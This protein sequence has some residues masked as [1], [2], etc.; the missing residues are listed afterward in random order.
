[1][2]RRLGFVL[3]AAAMGVVGL[4]TIS[5]VAATPASDGNPDLPSSC[6]LDVT[7]V[8]D[9]SAS[10]SSTE[11]EL[12]RQ[13]AATFASA[14]V[15][16]PS[17]LKTV[18]F[19]SRAT[20]IA[21]N[22]STTSNLNSIVFRDPA[23]Y[24]AP[25]SGA[26]SGGTNWDDGLEVVRR[27]NGGPGDLVVFLTD[28]DP[29]YRNEDEPN[30]HANDGSHALD[31]DG[32]TIGVAANLTAAEFEADA[33]KT[34]GAHMFGIG[35]GL[36]S[37]A[38]ET[39]LSAV[40]GDEELTLDGS[41][42]PNIPF[43]QADY[44]IAPNFGAL[45]QIIDAFVR[46]LCAPSLNVT[47][48]LQKADGTSVVAGASD[49]WSF[50]AAVSPT[51]IAWQSP[52]GASGSSATQS[53]DAS[54]GVSFKWSMDVNSATVDLTETVKPGWVYNGALCTVNALD[55][56]DP[57]VILDTVGT[58]APGAAE[59]L[60]ELQDLTVGLEEAVNCDVYNRELR[61][62]TIQV[63]KR[64]VP[65]GLSDPF[66]FTL[67]SGQAS[68]DV[69]SDLT[70]GQTGTFDPVPAGTYSI[71]EAAVDGYELTSATCDDLG[72]QAVEQ[73]SPTQLVTTE[74]Q[75]WRCTFTNTADPGSITVVKE[76][77]GA[78]GTFGFT[79][80]V[81][82]LGNFSLTTSLGS[83][84]STSSSVPVGTYSIEENDPAP[85]DLT[86]ATCTGQQD[87][88]AVFVG[89]GKDVVCTFTNVAPQ[90]TITV[91]KT[92]GTSTVGEPGGPVTYSVAVQNTSVEPLELTS[93]TDSI[94][95]GPA[96]DITTVA[97]PITATTCATGGTIAV[98]GSYTCQFTAT[99]TGNGG[100]TVTDVVTAVAVDS[101]DNQAT[102]DDDAS[103]AITDVAPTIAV[104]KTPSPTT[105]TEPGGE[106]TYTVEITNSGV[107]P[108]E[109]DAITDAV[110]GGAAIDVTTVA[111][112]VT[113]TTCDDL[114][115]DVLAIG[116]STSCTFTIAHLVDAS[117]HADGDIDDIVTVEASDDD[118]K[119]SGTAAAEVQ[120]VDAK[121]TVTITK[122]ASPTSVAETGPGQ[123]RT[124][125][126]T[127]GI[128]N[129]SP[130]TV[131]IDSIVDSVEGAPAVAVG[132]TCAALLGTT[133]APQ[134]STSC[135]FTMEV[136]GDEGDTIGDVVTV[137]VSD[138][139]DNTATDD[140]DAS[141]SITGLPSSIEVTKSAAPASVPEPGGDVTYTVEITNTSV[142]DSVTLGSVTDSVSG[143]PAFSVTGTCD[144]LIGTM[145]A[146]GA[147]TSCTF[148]LA[149][150]GN[151][152]DVV[153]DV[154]TVTGTD[155]DGD[156]VSDSGE[157]SVAITDVPS[158]I[159]VT[160]TAAPTSVTEPGGDVTFTVQ[161]TNTSKA[162]DVTIDSITDVVDGGAP[163]AV[164]GTCDDLIGTT[165]AP[166]ASTT[167]TFTLAVTGSNGDVVSDTVTVTG[168]DDD[169]DP[170][171]DSDSEVVDVKDAAATL[172]V[173]K[174]ADPT[175][176]DEPGGDVTFT[177]EIANTSPVDDVELT[178]ITDSVD[179]GPA[180]AVEGTCD[181]LIGTVLGAGD[182]VTC[183]F[184]LAVN[185]DA[186]DTVTDTVTVSGLD[187]EDHP[188]TA[189][190]SAVVDIDDV[191]PTGTVTK[192]AA[193]A[194]VPEPGGDVVFSVVVTNT[195]K[196][197][198]A[199]V[200]A[201]S[202][203]VDGTTVDVTTV[204]GPVKAT[205][206]ATGAVLAPGGTYTC[207]FTLAVA[208]NA[209]A[210]VVDTIRV[211]L[212]DD[213]DN[214]V[215]P[216][217]T[218][219]VAV[220]DVLPTIEVTKDNGG[221]TLPAPGGPVT[222]DVVVENTSA[223][224][225]VT[226]AEL[227]DSIEGGEPFDITTVAGP[228]TAT[229]CATGGAIAAGA[230]YACEFTL[231]VT[232][233][234]P[235]TETDVV[236]A[237]AVDDEGNEATDGDDAVT[238]L[239]AVADLAIDKEL[240][241]DLAVGEQG[242]YELEVTNLGPSTAANVVVTDT[243]P[244]GLTPV[245]ASGEG[246]ACTAT[247]QVVTCERPTLASDAPSTITVVVEVG[248]A[249]QGEEVTNVAEVDSDTPDPD[250][251]NNRDEETSEV[252]VVEDEDED[253]EP[254]TT[255]PPSDVS[256]DNV[257]D[258]TLPRTGSSPTPMVALALCMLGLGVIVLVGRRGARP[259]AAR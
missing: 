208:G 164:T 138:D 240:V 195:S 141:V 8:I 129:T 216:S 188:V 144:D 114:I 45:Q 26:G 84:S 219:T 211:T 256:P 59:D 79:S 210:A 177:V 86:Q 145:L 91:T 123:T 238:T 17:R 156:P 146:P 133:L 230:T 115:G 171:S 203:D 132:G 62:V 241:G 170:V 213:D 5:R 12:M 236:D 120:V 204:G 184:T 226:L 76:A 117:A 100:D 243:V 139:D 64:T 25:T 102:D 121:P 2:K 136:S 109:I 168:T 18:V 38:S 214:T 97:A 80:N 134:A 65:A 196:V 37:A 53:T 244:D 28:G 258:G 237:V 23:D 165:L 50:T 43:G 104:T 68:V 93:L 9:D 46:D 83:A 239:T 41:G 232:G 71:S 180:I 19:A 225:T 249:V 98:L 126:F 222:F 149:V 82:G 107:E 14:L 181:D 16:T 150:S 11:A 189:S 173:T 13:G 169:D 206:C 246:W 105:L 231:E 161:I 56:T 69:I 245:S 15:G 33:I 187:E 101:D 221:A 148:T 194:T 29:T 40:T 254:P 57:E 112:P 176:V 160:K 255:I 248:E 151:A 111:L 228:V 218:E 234:E 209:G 39:R 106:V 224:E 257:D 34:A 30:G 118:G 99:V 205:T 36:T 197:E 202:D 130:E 137:T 242:T 110:E 94:E 47:K 127:V 54:G 61:P 51:P 155:D 135:T 167:C 235:A 90:P 250:D 63:T 152:G 251:T 85:W 143:G 192:T 31:G 78:D 154:V 20:G 163:F 119:V 108:L 89:P 3:A 223:S 174:T 22:G 229:T 4:T 140:D 199:T 125:T 233:D 75:S 113:A 42:N 72:T 7:L 10:I 124:V 55:G 67:S 95:G 66:D 92:A 87:P 157:E 88:G 147:S 175:S 178:S 27:S 96:I 58:N 103:V 215:T 159:E 182:S 217:D 247:G 77:E 48:H 1:M 253:N 193:P 207:S 191:L 6:G 81:P 158:S 24:V 74:G 198:A 128:Q 153:P 252:P 179:G 190:D 116:A 32:S 122:T 259:G 131:T 201:I 60:A 186:G 212:A 166:G 73:A 52:A 185:G 49:P 35:I 162:D 44:T 220:T 183:T 227:T 200:T 70:H 21:A 172:T 142:A